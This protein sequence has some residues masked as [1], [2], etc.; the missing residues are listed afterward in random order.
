MQPSYPQ[1]TAAAI[2]FHVGGQSTTVVSMVARTLVR[3]KNWPAAVFRTLHSRRRQKARLLPA[4]LRSPCKSGRLLGLLLSLLIGAH[5]RA[6]INLPNVPVPQLPNVNLPVDID[7]T[8]NN[9]TRELDAR[10]LADLR[11]LRLRE[12][13]RGNRTVI[14]VDPRGAPIVRSE[15]LA[16]S[17]TEEALEQARGAGYSVVRERN[18]EGLEAR[19]VVL[20]AP[21][22]LSAR[23]ALRQLRELDPQGVYDY[24]HLY[25]DSGMLASD[26]L[27]GEPSTNV[28]PVGSAAGVKIGLIDGGVDRNHDVFRGVGIRQHGCAGKPVPSAHGTAVASLLA[29]NS[30]RF[31]GAAPGAELYAA[32]VFCGAPTGG[33]ADAVADAFAW[34]SREGVRTINVS[35]VGPSNVTLE[36]VIRIVTARGH[37]VNAAV[38]NDG[39][40]APPL[41]PA[42]YAGVVGV[43]AVDARHRVLLEAARG[44]QVDFAAPG[45]DMAAAALDQQFAAVRGTS[46]AAPIVAG[47][48]ARELSAPEKLSPD[49]AVARLVGQAV[50]LGSRGP[51]RTY[52]NG[53]VGGTLRIEPRLASAPE[54]K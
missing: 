40:A 30:E 54:N 38:G 49:Q 51:D 19:I 45:A 15:L 20:R 29:G 3:W 9:V 4:A 16:F 35:L 39:P 21:A 22:G 13:I 17:P 34:L 37:I 27:S 47:L 41:Y 18:L 12:L 5:A 33:A 2:F 50:D 1:T 25:T 6:Q 11:R 24:N 32:D 48:L 31:H 8:L 7:G 43:T 36:S 26:A 53:L 46:F 14:D 28:S 44:R 10:R 23:R 52:G 42:A